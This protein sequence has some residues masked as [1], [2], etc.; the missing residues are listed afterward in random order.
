MKNYLC[1]NPAFLYND[2]ADL[3]IESSIYLSDEQL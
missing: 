2:A 3:K 1:S